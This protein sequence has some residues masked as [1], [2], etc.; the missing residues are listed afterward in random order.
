[1]QT[2]ACLQTEPFRRPQASDRRRTSSLR[3]TSSSLQTPVCQSASRPAFPHHDL[4]P[5]RLFRG[6]ASSR[7]S[8]DRPLHVSE[9][10]SPA[11]TR[12]LRPHP[13]AEDETASMVAMQILHPRAEGEMASMVVTQILR[14]RLQAA[15][16]MA[17]MVVTQILHPHAEGEMASMAVTQIL[18][19]R[20][21]AAD[22]MASTAAMQTLRDHPHDADETDAPVGDRDPAQPFAD[23]PETR[24]SRL[25][26]V[27][28]P[29]DT[30]AYPQAAHPLRAAVSANAPHSTDA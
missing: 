28:R 7:H 10:V 11:A 18:R 3:Q 27:P 21:Q 15:D 6:T 13:Q 25:H 16:E 5:D 8:R 19:V 4:E 1:M 26:A 23:L 9:T 2:S 17:S 14:V 12:T 29:R 24:A 30:V 22:E 20:L